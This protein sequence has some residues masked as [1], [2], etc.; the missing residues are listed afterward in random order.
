MQKFHA[1]ACVIGWGAFYTFTFLAVTSL[2]EAAWMPATYAVL[3][4]A[5]LLAGMHCWM[6]LAGGRRRDPRPIPVRVRRRG[7]S[8]PETD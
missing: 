8:E 6:R 4:F 2:N 3:A 1:I 5:G 7:I